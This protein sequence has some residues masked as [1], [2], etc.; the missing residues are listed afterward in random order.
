VA[1]DGVRFAPANY[2]T[3]Q[4][5]DSLYIAPGNR[6]D[7]FVRAP[8]A[9]GSFELRARKVVIPRRSEKRLEGAAGGAGR[10]GPGAPATLAR[11]EVAAGRAGAYNT[12]L[13][14]ALG[15]LPR[16]LAN[17]PGPL[18]TTSIFRGSDSIPVVVFM[19][20]TYDGKNPPG[21]PTRFYLG[22]A[23]DPFMKYDPQAVYVPTSRTGTPLPMV[24]GQ[25]QT[26]QIVNYGIAINHPFHIHINPFQ[27]VYVRHPNPG[28]PY[29][30]YYD[31]LNAKAA[32]G[33]P[34]WMDVV[35]LPMPDTT[36]GGVVSQPGYVLIR[37]RYD[38]FVGEYVMHCHI[39]GH[40]ER[41]MMQL[42]QVTATG[43]PQPPRPAMH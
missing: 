10:S 20:S 29:G 8:A 23:Q 41:G 14:A 28:D 3:L 9:G 30:A 21:R 6:L 32:S 13:P 35:P 19:D 5:D 17:L 42:L 2:D 36:S 34:V 31:D 37:Q 38:D 39:L 40:E 27:V 11:I 7:V 16:F 24:L 22:N 43:R 26:W 33:A 15:P 25:V 12:R 1:R 4:A 18:D